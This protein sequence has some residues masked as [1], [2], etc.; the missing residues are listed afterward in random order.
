MLKVKRVQSESLDRVTKTLIWFE[1][2]KTDTAVLVIAGLIC[3]IFYDKLILNNA[4]PTVQNYSPIIAISGLVLTILMFL[5]KER[6]KKIKLSRAAR[7]CIIKMT[8]V[9]EALLISV[10]GSSSYIMA[11]IQRADDINEVPSQ[12]LLP[13]IFYGKQI[14]QELERQACD[15]DLSDRI[16][17]HIVKIIPKLQTLEDKFLEQKNLAAS[18]HIAKKSIANDIVFQISKQE[19]KHFLKQ[20][21]QP[22]VFE[23]TMLLVSSF[24][25]IWKISESC[26]EDL[27]DLFGEISLE[28]DLTDAIDKKILARY[29]KILKYLGKNPTS[30]DQKAHELFI[31]ID[32]HIYN[33]KI[34]LLLNADLLKESKL[35]NQV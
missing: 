21:S 18:I 30:I 5:H 22:E 35:R 16:K 14:A 28:P 17:E 6:E 31:K 29:K 25:S 4:S 7:L 20:L 32:K 24:Q 10:Q 13:E 8:S 11:S 2:R 34:D 3:Y 1:A 33:T 15:T 26:A 19:T 27:L 23:K 9:L 12:T